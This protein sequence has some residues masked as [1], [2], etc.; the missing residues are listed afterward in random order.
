M[1]FRGDWGSGASERASR[2]ARFYDGLSLLILMWPAIG[3]M[4]LLGSTRTWGYAPGMAISFLG[5]FLVL[6]RPLVFRNVPVVSPPPG[7]WIFSVLTA[8]VVLGIPWASVPYAARWE[9]LRWVCL[10]SGSG[11]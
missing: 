2:P 6:A 11:R 3:G 9:A 8:Y 10:I 7:F 1:Q 4:W 5:S